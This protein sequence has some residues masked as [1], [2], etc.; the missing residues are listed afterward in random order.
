MA[1]DDALTTDQDVAGLVDVLAN[2][3]DPD[4]DALSVTTPSP[5]A[6]HGDVACTEGCVHVHA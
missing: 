3:S 5:A 6:E 4:G 2:D 1:V